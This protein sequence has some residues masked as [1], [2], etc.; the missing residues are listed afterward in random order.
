MSTLTFRRESVCMGDDANNGKYTIELPDTA[1]LGDLM[2]VILHGGN[3]NDWPIPYTGANSFWVIKSNIGSLAD[4]YTDTEGDWHIAYLTGTENTPLKSLGITWTF[5]DRGLDPAE[6]RSVYHGYEAAYMTGKEIKEYSS[7][8]YN[9]VGP[10]HEQTAGSKINLQQFKRIQDHTRY[11]VFY[12]DGFFKIMDANTG[13]EIYW[14]TYI[15]RKPS[16]AL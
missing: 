12:N 13:A 3:G 9:R 8:A 6:D 1:A 10:Y 14:I 5:G 15:K 4:I 16:R 11:R 2:N 7:D